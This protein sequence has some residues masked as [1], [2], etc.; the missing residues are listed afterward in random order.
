VAVKDAMLTA[1]SK[2]GTECGKVH[3]VG[4]VIAAHDPGFVLLCKEASPM[5]DAN[6][7][8]DYVIV[9]NGMLGKVGKCS[10]SE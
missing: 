1:F 10:S 7:Y 6:A 2:K 9:R 8:V 3:D 5:D 4:C